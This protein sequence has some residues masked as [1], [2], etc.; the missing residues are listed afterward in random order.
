[1]DWQIFLFIITTWNM[2]GIV[3]AFLGIDSDGFEY[4]N[5]VWIYKRYHVN[6]FGAALICI[7]HNLLCPIGSVCYWIY[8]LCTV[9]RR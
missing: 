6:Y 4:V 5:P 3:L 1:M 7:I 8:K 2:V 9:G